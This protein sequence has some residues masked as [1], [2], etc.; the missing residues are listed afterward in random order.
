MDVF[1]CRDLVYRDEE[2]LEFDFDTHRATADSRNYNPPKF[3]QAELRKIDI[4]DAAAHGNDYVSHSS[5][6]GSGFKNIQQ[7]SSAL[8]FVIGPNAR[9]LPPLP[10]EVV[11]SFFP[12]V[13]F[14]ILGQLL[15]S[16]AS[17]IFLGF[18]EKRMW[19]YLLVHASIV[20]SFSNISC[21]CKLESV[22]LSCIKCLPFLINV[23]CLANAQYVLFL[24]NAYFILTIA[25]LL[26]V[27]VHESMVYILC[28]C[29]HLLIYF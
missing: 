12:L 21:R 9:N 4:P 14:M 19:N 13:S 23:D 20:N 8:S 15:I 10:N 6:P 24:F 16:F 7:S 11:S 17:M 18:Y 5:I 2:Q 26:F 3:S 25:F 1:L 27:F 28:L 22:S 29:N